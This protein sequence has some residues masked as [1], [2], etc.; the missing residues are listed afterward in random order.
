MRSHPRPY[1]AKRIETFYMDFETGRGVSSTGR[2][3]SCQ[4]SQGRKNPTLQDKLDTVGYLASQISLEANIMFTGKVPRIEPGQN[5]RARHWLLV[6]TGPWEA[7][8]DKGHWLGTPP[9]GRFRHATT[10][11][12]IEVRT[13]AEW[14]GSTVLSPELAREAFQILDGLIGDQFGRYLPNTTETGILKTPAATGTNLWAASLPTAMPLIPVEDDIAE[15]LHATSGQHHLEHSVAGP[16]LDPHPDVVPLIDPKVLP[17]LDSFAYVDGRFMYASLCRGLGLGPGIRLKRSEAADLLRDDPYAR[18]RYRIKFTVPDTW[19]NVGIFGVQHPDKRD[20]W[21]YPNRP[22]AVGETWADAAEVF[23]AQKFGW[24]IEPL[25]AVVFTKKMPKSRKRFYGDDHIARRGV[26]EARPLD[27]WSKKLSEGRAA[28][29]DDPTLPPTLKKAVGAALRSIL[30]QSIGAFASRG[31]GKTI[32]T[33]DPKTIPEQ[34]LDSME[35]MGKSFVYFVPQAMT[36]RQEAFYRPE[37]AWQV[38]GRGRA[39]TLYNRTNDQE[40]GALTLPGS[41]IVGINGDAIYTS[42]LP[43]WALS[44]SQ[45]GADDGQAGRLRLQGYLSGPVRTPVTRN[46]RDKLRDQAIKAGADATTA[47]IADQAT[48]DFEFAYQDDSPS[49]FTPESED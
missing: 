17:R 36:Q 35:R 30:I 11:K 24:L 29:A 27:L 40:C 9:T 34:Y 7:D 4:P 15:E 49:Q 3:F 47:D 8:P 39:K 38:W 20:G 12:R 19:H 31:R 13:A 2:S 37:L 45:N 21:Y 26:T 18:A 16:S 10:G 25:E 6:N 22:G 46:D 48:F 5:T 1:A 43:Q 42:T 41:S 14:F 23:V 28:I 33:D 44:T 32:K